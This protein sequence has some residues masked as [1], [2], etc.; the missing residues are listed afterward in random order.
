MPVS[1]VCTRARVCVTPSVRSCAGVER[2]ARISMRKRAPTVR[3]V[4][5]GAECSPPSNESQT[6]LYFSGHKL[7]VWAF[8]L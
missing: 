2:C 8:S 7:S 3:F 6:V 1:D 5:N 4:K